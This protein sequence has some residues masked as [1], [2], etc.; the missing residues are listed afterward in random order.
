FAAP[1]AE[2]VAKYFEE[3]AEAGAVVEVLRGTASYDDV[4]ARPV[5]LKL[6]CETCAQRLAEETV[7]RGRFER[8]GVHIIK[9]D[10]ARSLSF[11]AV[12][13]PGACE[14]VYPGPP[15][16]DPILL[17]V[18]RAEFN[19]RAAGRWRF[20]VRAER[21]AEEPLVFHLAL[22]AA[23][24]FLCLSYHRLDGG[25]RERLP[26]HYLLKVA[27]ALA[28]YKFGAE[29]F[30]RAASAHPWFR[31]V[32]A[33]DAPMPEGTLDD[34]EY[35]AGRVGGEGAERVAAYL[36]ASDPRC[37]AAAAARASSRSGRLTAF[38]GVI[39]SAEGRRFLAKRYGRE[40]VPVG[41]SDLELLAAC[42]RKYFFER[43]LVLEAWEEP[44][45]RL[46]MSPLARGR[47]V[48]DVLCE[49]YRGRLPLADDDVDAEAARM[50]EE[51]LAATREEGELS[52]P[53]VFEMER[54]L[55][56]AKLAAFVRADLAGLDGWSPTYFELR[57]GRRPAAGDD[58]ASS[59][60][61]FVLELG[62]GERNGGERPA[63]AEVHGRIDR[64]DLRDGAAKVLDY[65]TGR[66]AGYVGNLD[67]GRQLQP[68]LYLMAYAEL[69]GADVASSPAGYCF[70]LEA[71]E[72]CKYVVGGKTPLDAGAVR[73]LVGGLLALAR[74]GLFVA[75]REG[76]GRDVCR[77]CECK[78][79]CDAARN[80][81][82]DEKWAAPEAARLLELREIT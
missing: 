39:D 20:N 37:A 82:S 72:K 1:A 42:P 54:R 12:F 3:K 7:R 36:A 28:G 5:T 61:P 77:Y 68:P 46:A 47:V 16:Q 76:N 71:G 51:A 22:G 59:G 33:S 78:V 55:I 79:I 30:D 23:R 45:E 56:S 6:F 66:R 48:H 25:G 74:D 24:E 32:G 65:K 26:S 60:R 40:V 13:V 43:I 57:F 75:G 38:D 70:P 44:E 17:D 52:R 64:V 41:A 49:L 21:V 29:D 67:G 58:P 27:G 80:Y 8:D 14:G 63:A 53:F 69:F 34:A 73:R 19:D 31:R 35:W 9:L 62:G 2:L 81:L 4:V 10:R 50:V 11:S 18:E 15:A